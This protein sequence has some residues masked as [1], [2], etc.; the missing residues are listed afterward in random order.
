MEPV[1]RCKLSVINVREI[2]LIGIQKEKKSPPVK[3]EE[4]SH[5][6]DISESE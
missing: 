3:I 5:S 2:T 1:P 4:E 6:F